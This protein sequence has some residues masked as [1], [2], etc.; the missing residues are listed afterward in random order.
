MFKLIL[1]AKWLVLFYKSLCREPSIAV[2]ATLYMV[3]IALQDYLIVYRIRKVFYSFVVCQK[4][5][6]WKIAPE[7]F[8]HMHACY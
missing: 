8:L 7:P 4:K 5:N 1:S 2:M 3:D 6:I